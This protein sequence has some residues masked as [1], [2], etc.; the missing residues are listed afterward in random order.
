M[1][2]KGQEHVTTPVVGAHVSVFN[3][4]LFMTSGLRQTFVCS[5]FWPIFQFLFGNISCQNYKLGQNK[6]YITTVILISWC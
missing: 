5:K 2:T 4:F 6:E 1:R 3:G